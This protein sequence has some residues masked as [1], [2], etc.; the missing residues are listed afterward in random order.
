VMSFKKVEVTRRRD[1]TLSLSEDRSHK[2]NCS[3]DVPIQAPTWS[4]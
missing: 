4:R 1:C 2:S 3:P